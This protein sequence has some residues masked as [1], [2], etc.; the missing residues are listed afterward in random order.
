MLFYY[1]SFLCQ[2]NSQVQPETLRGEG[3]FSVPNTVTIHI[4][5]KSNQEHGKKY[6]IQDSLRRKS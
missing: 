5:G 3:K 4:S 6:Q 1:Q 2:P